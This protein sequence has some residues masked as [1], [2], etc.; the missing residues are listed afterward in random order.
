MS[1]RTILRGAAGITSASAG[2]TVATGSALGREGQGGSGVIAPHTRQR[3]D[4]NSK[5][6]FRIID[7][8][9][10]QEF[11]CNGTLRTW[12]C[13]RIKF[14]TQPEAETHNL[15][16]N[17]TR[18]VDTIEGGPYPKGRGYQNKDGYTGWHTFTQKAHAC[19]H[20]GGGLVVG[21]HEQEQAIHVSFKPIHN[22]NGN[23][24]RN[25]T[26]R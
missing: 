8:I 1:R 9:S 25:G 20:Y 24:N 17:P 12:A 14:E 3:H 4:M 11:T 21:R 22:S 16:L 6:K 5:S 2:L 7:K 23:G 26:R 15:L 10:E 19:N 13:Y 18:R